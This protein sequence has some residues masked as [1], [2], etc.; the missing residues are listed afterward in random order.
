M[1]A[2]LTATNG[3]LA[4]GLWAWRARATSSLPV[5]DSPVISTLA[6][7]PATRR[8]SANTSCIDRRAPDDVLEA[9][10]AGHLLAQ[11]GHLGAQRLLG[12]RLVDHQHQL[13]DL[14]RLGDVVER[15]QLHRP[16]GGVDRA[17]G[18]DGDDVGRGLHLAH[19]AQQIQTVQVGHLHVR[20]H[21]VDA[22]L[23]DPLD[24]G[25][26]AAGDLDPEALVLQLLAQV[27]AHGRV[28]VDH[29]DH[30]ARGGAGAGLA[31]HR[32]RGARRRAG[33]GGGA[34]AHGEAL[35]ASLCR[36]PRQGARRRWAPRRP[37]RC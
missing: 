12:Q 24:A 29:Q 20:D 33:W 37:R 4:R 19:L 2:Q 34:G 5:P 21:Q 26:A 14:E 17:E 11:P 36:A 7:E 15:A 6:C 10:A 30:R 35:N 3:R 1:A 28:V 22:A 8:M 18:G 16:D 23:L 32:R 31:G 27:V 13:L 9:D 25:P